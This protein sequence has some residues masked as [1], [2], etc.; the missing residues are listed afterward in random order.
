LIHPAIIENYQQIAD[1]ESVIIPE[2]LRVYGRTGRRSARS[3]ESQPAEPLKHIACGRWKPGNTSPTVQHIAS[4]RSGSQLA[5]LKCTHA[6]CVI[7]GIP[8]IPAR[9]VPCAKY[10]APYRKSRSPYIAGGGFLIA[11]SGANR[12]YLPDNCVSRPFAV[13]QHPAQTQCHRSVDSRQSPRD[14]T[15]ITG[16]TKTPS[17]S[18]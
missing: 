17:D 13:G 10:S 6:L 7:L 3:V 1:G 4:D 15:R 18:K 9:R 2:V 12:M 14:I 8:P 11:R 5:W 16:N